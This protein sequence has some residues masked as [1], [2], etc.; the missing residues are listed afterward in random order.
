VRRGQEGG[1]RAARDNLRHGK[2]RS[3]ASPMPRSWGKARRGNACFA[4]RGRRRPKTSRRMAQENARQL[5]TCVAGDTYYGDLFRLSHFTSDSIFFGGT[6]GF[7]VWRDDQNRIVARDGAGVSGNLAPSTAAARG[8]APLGGVFKTNRFSAGECPPGT[9]LARAP[10]KASHWILPARPRRA[11]AL[12]RLDQ[13]KLLKIARESGLR[14]AHF[15]AASRGA[16]L[17]DW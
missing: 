13:A 17:P 5:E 7:L 2:G 15:C 14:D 10:G 12:V 8:C 6:R 4:C 16:A 3:G 1:P 9:R 11:I